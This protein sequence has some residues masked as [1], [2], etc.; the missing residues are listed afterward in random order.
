M[1]QE[2]TGSRQDVLEAAEQR[3]Y[4]IRQGRAAQ[5]LTPISAVLLD[6][7]DRLAMSWPPA[8]RRRARPVHRPARPWIRPSP[9]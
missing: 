7:Y 3:I 2:G 4:A 5:G 9:A 6:V 8:T 1:V